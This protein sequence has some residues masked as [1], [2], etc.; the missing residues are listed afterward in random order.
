MI[1]PA[2]VD[3]A[4]FL[5]EWYGPPDFA[6]TDPPNPCNWIPP[7]LLDWHRLSSRWSSPIMRVKRMRSLSDI[8]PSDGIVVF[9]KDATGDWSWGFDQQDSTSVYD[10]EL[11]ESWERCVEDLPEFLLHNTLSEATFGA[12]F[13]RESPQVQHSFL[14]AILEGVTE[15]GFGGWRWPRPGGRM[16]IGAGSLVEVIPALDPRSP[17]NLREGWVEV[18]V[19]AI[20]EASLKHLDDLPID[21]VKQAPVASAR[22]V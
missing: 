20:S 8:S 9:L 10:A 4:G 14:D 2:D 19:A 12:R 3:L 18:R 1:D 6:P 5:T 21:W 7:A 15:I 17:W 11:G 22:V 16:Y 13:W